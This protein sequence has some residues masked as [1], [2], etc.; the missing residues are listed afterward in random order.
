MKKALLLLLAALLLCSVAA[1]DKAEKA[2][3]EAATVTPAAQPS[4]SAASSSG[5]NAPGGEP[6]D[7]KAP[8]APPAEVP[9]DYWERLEYEWENAP[10]Q[11]YVWTIT[12][13][14]LVT[15]D[16]MGLAVVD[17]DLDLSCSHVGKSMLG[18]YRGEMAMNYQAD[19][20]G[21]IAL[22]TLAGGT[23][24]YDADGWFKNDNFL[25]NLEA[26]DQ[27]L[28]EQFPETL[29]EQP[30]D[31]EE[32]AMEAAILESYLGSLRAESESF[33]DSKPAGMWYDWD[34]HMTEGDMSG[35]IE[36]TGIAYGTTNASGG[37]DASGVQM[38]GSGTTDIPGIFHY[39]ERYSETLQNPFP[40]TIKV[41][42]DGNVVM[43]LYSSQG[44]PVT[45]KFYGSIDKVP[46]ENTILP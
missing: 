2:A 6:S 45:V 17:Y 23:A 37:V 22:A 11:G 25:M 3:P 40:Y 27:E 21:V 35:Y 32:A 26:Y 12:I 9:E 39:T 15:L 8:E 34:F 43:E 18:V 24:D 7:G 38:A 10:E 16:V 14:K 46:V 28:D 33:E 31:A 36:M 20:S 13:D 29:G 41:Y 44:G 30:E 4:E 5:G 19:L 1:C 42:E